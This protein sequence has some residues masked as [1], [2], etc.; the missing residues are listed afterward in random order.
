M[1]GYTQIN[2]VGKIQNGILVFEITGQL[3][4]SIGLSFLGSGFSANGASNV[5]YTGVFQVQNGGSSGSGWVSQRQSDDNPGTGYVPPV[6][7]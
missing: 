2:Y 1:G 6:V 4:S 7:N 3:T 5:K